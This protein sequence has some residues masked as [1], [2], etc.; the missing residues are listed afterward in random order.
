MIGPQPNGGWGWAQWSNLRA[1]EA[2]TSQFQ[3]IHL[4]MLDLD[5]LQSLVHGLAAMARLQNNPSEALPLAV[6]IDQAVDRNRLRGMLASNQSEVWSHGQRVGP[7]VESGHGSLQIM[8][9]NHDG[10]LI[11]PALMALCADGIPPGPPPL[12]RSCPVAKMRSGA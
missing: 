5:P 10:S 4:S 12:A 7:P 6:S 2:Q 1:Y 9:R 3:S 8:V 11:T